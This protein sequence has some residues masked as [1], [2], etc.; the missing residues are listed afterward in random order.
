VIRV[1][2]I[3]ESRVEERVHALLG[4]WPS[5]DLAFCARPE[6]VA[7]ILSAPAGDR[8]RLET[9]LATLRAGFG[10]AALPPGCRGL[11]GYVGRL[12]E[13]RGWKL[14]TAESCTGGMIAAA[15][16]DVAGASKWFAGAVVAYANEWKEQALGVRPGTLERAGA[17]SEQTVLEMVDGLCDRFGV[18]AGIAVS[19]IAGPTGGSPDKPV[20]TVCIATRA[21]SR[22]TARTAR[23][24]GNRDTV[25]RRAVMSALDQLRRDLLPA[26]PA[27]KTEVPNR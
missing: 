11:P 12:L 15:L 25:R 22:R 14:A 5:E 17:V 2:G 9:A 26:D 10:A 23:F 18:E 7:V 16:T 27:A 8:D 20:G 6:A 13:D 4:N 21:G 19:G 3:P 24:P 1:C